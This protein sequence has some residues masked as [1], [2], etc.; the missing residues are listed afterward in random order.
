MVA[1][2]TPE[3]GKY[4][5]I[6]FNQV[7]INNKNNTFI[8]QNPWSVEFSFGDSSFITISSLKNQPF[9]T[10][11]GKYNI[12]FDGTLPDGVSKMSGNVSITDVDGVKNQ[13]YSGMNFYPQ[14]IF[15]DQ[16]NAIL[17]EHDGSISSYLEST[18]D[19]M[20]GQGSIYFTDMRINVD[21]FEI[22]V[23]DKIYDGNSGLLWVDIIAESYNE[24]SN[25]VTEGIS[26][27]FYAVQFNDGLDGS[28]LI[29][30]LTSDNY[31]NT[32]TLNIATLFLPGQDPYHFPIN[33]ISFSVVPG[34]TWVSP[35][36]GNSYNLVNEVTL[37]VDN[38]ESWV[39]KITSSFPDQEIVISS[40]IVKYEGTSK[41]TTS[42][43]KKLNG[44]L[45]PTKGVGW[46]ELLPTTKTLG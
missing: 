39:I 31:L 25:A 40:T 10:P 35:V 34:N 30:Q 17:S 12:S 1:I 4:K 45:L 36:S 15:P 27:Q 42:L 21:K 32:G 38:G 33:S 23:N 6:G 18:N 13:G 11:G 5:Y 41:V 44:I 16:R 19:N 28:L 37:K 2:R 14:W 43:N 26:W 3:D 9:G 46:I 29:N 20:V 8:K 7:S 24:I 22:N